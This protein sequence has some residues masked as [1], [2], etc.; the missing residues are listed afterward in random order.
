VR[1]KAS[2]AT[3]ST[4]EVGSSRMSMG[5]RWSTATASCNRCLT[6]SGK[7][8]RLGISHGLQVVSFEQLIDSTFN[9]I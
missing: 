5:G 7:A 1:Q 9:L 3:G 4:P 8:R 6:P 2:R